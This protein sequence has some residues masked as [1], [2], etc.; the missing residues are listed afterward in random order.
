MTNLRGTMQIVE[1]CLQR[2]SFDD[3]S[4]T[5]MVLVTWREIMAKSHQKICFISRQAIGTE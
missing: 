2:A 1:I 5:F 4:T 3:L